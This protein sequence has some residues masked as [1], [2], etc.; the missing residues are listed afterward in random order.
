M[1]KPVRHRAVCLFTV[2]ITMMIDIWTLLHL[3]VSVMVDCV[4]NANLALNLRTNVGLVE[5]CC[6]MVGVWILHGRY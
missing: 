4:N 6:T 3:R 5:L 1:V 2:L